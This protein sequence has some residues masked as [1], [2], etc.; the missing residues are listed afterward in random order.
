M[1]PCAI[2]GHA[3]QSFGRPDLVRRSPN[4]SVW[5]KTRWV[6]CRTWLSTKVTV[7]WLHFYQVLGKII[8]WRRIKERELRGTNTIYHRVPRQETIS[9]FE[10]H[11]KVTQPSLKDGRSLLSAVGTRMDTAETAVR[12]A[13][14]HSQV[15]G[16]NKWNGISGCRDS[17]NRDWD[18]TRYSLV[19]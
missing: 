8:L 1:P 10:V 2:L 17:D 12:N 5:A 4:H 11:Y 13:T 19:N 14:H 15:L 7:L 18:V 9:Y 6:C 3:C 16:R